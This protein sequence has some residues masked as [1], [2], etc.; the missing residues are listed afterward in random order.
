MLIP[1]PLEGFSAKLFLILFFPAIVLCQVPA[2][3]TIAI[4]DL[5]SYTRI[6]NIS[7]S[8]DG[9]WVTYL[10]IKPNVRE[11]LYHSALLLQPTN[12]AHQV[13][14]LA[15]FQ[16]TA[17]ETFLDTGEMKSFGGLILWSPDSKRLAFTKREGDKVQIW[18]RAIDEASNVKI[19][20]AFPQVDLDS[21]EAGNESLRFRVTDQMGSSGRSS[22]LGDPAIH[23]TDQDNFWWSP[24]FKKDNPRTTSRLYRYVLAT[25]E[26]LELRE[27]SGAGRVDDDDG[28][29]TYEQAKWPTNPKEVKYA[30]HPIQSPDQEMSI[31]L[32]LTVSNSNN[33]KTATRDYFVGLKALG[34]DR[35]PR[36]VLHS[37][38]WISYFKWSAD[39]QRAYA[40]QFDPEYTAVLS[41]RVSDANVT[42]ILRTPDHLSDASWNT[43]ADSFVAVRQ[44]SSTP[45]ELVKFNLK[46]KQFDVLA[47]PNASFK[48][49]NLPEVRFRQVNN[50]LGGGIFGRLVF[51]NGYVKGKRYP[52]IFTT[53]RAG[54]GF[55]EGGVGNEFPIYPYAANGFVV[56]AMDAGI[57]NML[58]SSGDL[59]FTLMRE[60][61]PL[62]AMQ[63]II[64]QLSDEGLIDPSKCGVTGLS[65]GGDIAA[66]AAWSSKTFAAASLAGV[67]LDP[68]SHVLNSVAGE[69]VLA[70]HG[71]P[72][73]DDEGLKKWRATSL[74]MNASLMTTP[75]LIQSPDQ[76][77]MVSLEAFKALKH[78]GVPV[79]WYVYP[80]EGHMKF[81]PRNKYYVYQRNLDW[82]RFWLKGQEDPNPAKKDQYVH[83]RAMREE[84]QKRHPQAPKP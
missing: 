21:W 14:E 18:I 6:R 9:N 11:N 54:T 25:R 73:P 7:L 65:Y 70:G 81:Q 20:K 28:T 69:K 72:Y 2:Q 58:S 80:G 60:K 35:P 55:L 39:S 13:I 59:D 38:R 41:I 79:E 32:G 84:F 62:D 4:E 40:I 8:P 50:P 71:F 15:R 76:E 44:R 82:M 34:D 56:F 16:T 37:P 57:S 27:K 33:I 77:A 78:Y 12:P 29:R 22:E 83:W 36:E 10:V 17:A 75:L 45:D 31:F 42:E 61:R 23:I 43:Q 24:W 49:K 66:Y 68:L 3:Q 1:R 47:S 64:Q 30:V 46:A 26:L 48:D 5:V 53:Y 67:W 19:A 51:P 52:L 74:A 63:T